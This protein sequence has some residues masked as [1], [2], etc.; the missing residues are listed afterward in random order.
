MAVTEIM[1]DPEFEPTMEPR[2][3]RVLSRGAPCLFCGEWI[4]PETPETF[5]LVV[6]NPTREAEYAAHDACLE[7]VRHPSVAPPS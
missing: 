7:R 1:R 5:R 6:L 4:E 3:E 2:H